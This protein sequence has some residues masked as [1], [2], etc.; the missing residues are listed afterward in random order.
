MLCSMYCAF[1]EFMNVYTVLYPYNQYNDD[2][3]LLLF[4]VV[5]C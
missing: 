3:F 2:D 5:P 1:D 4:S